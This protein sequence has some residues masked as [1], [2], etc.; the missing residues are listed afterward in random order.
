[1]QIR[2]Q[3]NYF[4]TIT[5]YVNF[6]YLHKYPAKV[7][8]LSSLNVTKIKSTYDD[9]G[10]STVITAI[11]NLD[12]VN[13]VIIRQSDLLEGTSCVTWGI[14]MTRPFLIFAFKGF[15]ILNYNYIT[16]VGVTWDVNVKTWMP[17]IG[18]IGPINKIDLHNHYREF[19]NFT[20][21]LILP[22][23]IVSGYSNEGFVPNWRC[24]LNV[25][26]MSYDG[27]NCNGYAMYKAVW[28]NL[29]SNLKLY[30]ALYTRDELMIMIT[31]LKKVTTTQ[32]LTMGAT[33]LA[34]LTDT[35][36]KI[37]TDKGWTLA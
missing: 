35:D 9:G 27:C 20:K 6:N 13:G 36:I 34:K 3:K 8:E 16:N 14:Q 23:I 15:N 2:L 7:V 18:G 33:N 11:E 25:P 37:A 10:Y 26:Y 12:N 31:T 28:V 24:N 19:P 22:N 29:K 1:M 17:Y 32:T 4:S 30:E 5:D 21:G